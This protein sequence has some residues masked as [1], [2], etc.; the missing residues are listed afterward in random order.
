MHVYVC[1]FVYV[2]VCIEASILEHAYAPFLW[3]KVYGV[4]VYTYTHKRNR[5]S[6]MSLCF[7]LEAS[8]GHFLHHYIFK[9]SISQC[10]VDPY[11]PVSILR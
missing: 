4:C 2:Y 5:I 9:P 1:V 10:T 3:F 8:E 7:N 6:Q 11:Q